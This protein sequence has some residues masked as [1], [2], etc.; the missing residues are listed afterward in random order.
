MA[1]CHVDDYSALCDGERDASEL[2]YFEHR[3]EHGHALAQGGRTLLSWM[4]GIPRTGAAAGRDADG[5]QAL[6]LSVTFQPV[7]SCSEMTYV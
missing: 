1:F 6:R 7:W 2:R 3:L 5:E 4:H